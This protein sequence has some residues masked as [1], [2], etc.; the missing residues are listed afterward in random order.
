MTGAARPP[1]LRI[2][3]GSGPDDAVVRRRRFEAAYPDV[4]IT[5]PETHA[6]MW[7]ARQDGKI[8]ARDYQLGGLLD[9]LE[10]LDLP[11]PP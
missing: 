1:R 10:S 3:D 8:L 2:I 4:T 9:A 5:P 7:I 11:A 6:S